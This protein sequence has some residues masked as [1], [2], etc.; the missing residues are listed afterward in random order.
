MK[1]MSLTQKYTRYIERKCLVISMHAGEEEFLMEK[2][3]GQSGPL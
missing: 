2:R 3:L 1:E